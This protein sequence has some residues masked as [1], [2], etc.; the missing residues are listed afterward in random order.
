MENMYFKCPVCGKVLH[1]C[2]KKNIFPI[3]Y[4]IRCKYC[5]SVFGFVVKLFVKAHMEETNV[6]DEDIADI[7][8]TEEDN[9]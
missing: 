4:K 8:E 5:K 3:N 2:N 9:V 7:L 6:T 1:A